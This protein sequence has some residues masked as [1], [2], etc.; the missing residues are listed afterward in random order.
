MVVSTSS[1]IW[2]QNELDEPALTMMLSKT[3]PMQNGKD[4]KAHCHL[5]AS[6]Y[7]A[8]IKTPNECYTASASRVGD[9]Q[10]K[11]AVWTSSCPARLRPVLACSQSWKPHKIITTDSS[12][13]RCSNRAFLFECMHKVII[14]ES[15]SEKRD[16]KQ[17]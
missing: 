12:P 3:V 14:R 1:N 16:I 7:S 6:N 11:V 5:C 15:W 10:P 2:T 17:V 9:Q 4:L 8:C 13:G